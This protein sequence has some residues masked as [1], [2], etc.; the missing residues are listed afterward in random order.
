MSR[1]KQQLVLSAVD[2][3][4]RSA[5]GHAVCPIAQELLRIAMER[6]A[7]TA[8][9]HRATGFVPEN[10]LTHSSNDRHT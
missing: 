2:A 10:V 5:G 3:V 4:C 8:R 9:S 1:L 7:P 6:Y